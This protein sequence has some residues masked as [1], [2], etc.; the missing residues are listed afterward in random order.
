MMHIINIIDSVKQ[1]RRGQLVY[2]QGQTIDGIYLIL[3][4]E[5]EIIKQAHMNS[6][7]ID[8]ADLKK[9]GTQLKTRRQSKLQS[10]K[11]ISKNEIIGLEDILLHNETRELTCRCHSAP[12]KTYFIKKVDFI[13]LV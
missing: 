2:Q 7:E 6:F 5:F 10:F 11:V 13:N 1:F 9:K 4:G 3:Y 12:S 8:A